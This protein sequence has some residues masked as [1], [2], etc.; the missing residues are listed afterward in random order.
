MPIVGGGGGIE[1]G[2]AGQR[3][4]FGGEAVEELCVAPLGAEAP[5]RVAR[6]ALHQLAHSPGE[7]R[8]LRRG[9]ERVPRAASNT[10]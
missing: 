9:P 5:P 10:E 2:E 1:A 3:I 7:L 6:H 4:E 8:W